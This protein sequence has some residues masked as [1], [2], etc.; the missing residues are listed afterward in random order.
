VRRRTASIPGG[1]AAMLLSVSLARRWQS[2]PA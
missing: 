2:P 1:N